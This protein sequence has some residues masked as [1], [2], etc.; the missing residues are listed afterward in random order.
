MESTPGP[1]PAVIE[2]GE[3]R[4]HAAVLAVA[5]ALPG[6][7][8]PEALSTIRDDLRS[9]PL[10][11]ASVAGEVVAFAVVDPREGPVAELLWIGVAPARQGEGIGGALVERIVADLRQAG[12]ALLLVKTLDDAAGYPPYQRTMRFYRR[13]GF[14]HCLT[15]DPFPGWDPGNPCALLARVVQENRRSSSE[16]SRR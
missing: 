15:L 4:H 3:P 14:L 13:C 12:V 16:L 11:V 1:I 6:Y 2:R 9:H 5:G 7:F 8:T 10:Y